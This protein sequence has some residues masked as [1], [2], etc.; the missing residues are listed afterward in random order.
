MVNDVLHLVQQH[1]ATRVVVLG[2]TELD[3]VQLCLDGTSIGK[4]IVKLVIATVE[5][6]L[7]EETPL[8]SSIIEQGVR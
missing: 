8:V 6:N 3:G 2:G 7:R 4:N 1:T 5:E